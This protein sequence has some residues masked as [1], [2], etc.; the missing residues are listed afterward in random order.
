MIEDLKQRLI[1]RTLVRIREQAL[2]YLVYKQ[3]QW[4]VTSSEELPANSLFGQKVLLIPDS[5]TFFRCQNFPLSHIKEAN[6][7]EAVELDIATWAPWDTQ[8]SHYYWP[9]K[10]G[11]SWRVAVWIWPTDSL[12]QIKGIEN[13][14]PTHIMPERAWRIAALAR[15]TL[16][17]I[18]VDKQGGGNEIHSV[19][20]SS[21][22][23]LQ[24]NECASP[25]ESQRFKLSLNAEQQEYPLIKDVNFQKPISKALRNAQQEGI[26]DWTD[27]LG[28]LKPIGLL[29]SIYLLWLFGTT[30]IL[31]QHNAEFSQQAANARSEAIE[32]IEQRE[33]VARIHE[34]LQAIQSLRHEQSHFEDV[35][36]ALS[37]TLPDDAWLE[38][39]EYNRNDG[40]WITLSGLAQQSAG[41]A[42][43]LEAM[44]EIEQAMFVGDIRQDS[45]G[46]EPFSLRLKLREGVLQ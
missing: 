3:E 45:R 12:S 25:S 36:M 8:W 10:V 14:A 28:W 35:L 9:T 23:P 31:W 44:P 27:P 18:F 42:A 40:G 19:L 22:M 32:V 13:L 26:E 17:A 21:G 43:V 24:I 7:S 1:P 41:L 39:I 5:D 37:Q 20:S 46:L 38:A 34:N 2:Q 29:A 6:L 33:N 11:D 16:P 4:S 30:L 15:P